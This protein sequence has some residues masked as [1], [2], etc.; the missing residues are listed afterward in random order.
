[1]I[2]TASGLWP[3]K[4]H[5]RK[6]CQTLG[7]TNAFPICREVN[8]V[9]YQILHPMVYVVLKVTCMQA[10]VRCLNLARNAF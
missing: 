10:I 2:L 3:H 9:Q 6:T 8:L 4:S 7:Q 1:L 5:S